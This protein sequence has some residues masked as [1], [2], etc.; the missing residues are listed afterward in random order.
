MERFIELLTT[1]QI[2][3]CLIGGQAL[4]AYVEPVVSLDLD[5]AVASDQSAA[6]DSLL[7]REFETVRFPH[8]LNLSQPDTRI[9]AQWFLPTF[10][11]ASCK[12]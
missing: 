9:C 10:S 12:S 8:S 2:R 3:F 5:V 11:P 7:A 4:N 6:V 1:H